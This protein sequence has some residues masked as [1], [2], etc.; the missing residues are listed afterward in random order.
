M[1]QDADWAHRLHF[2][3][4]GGEGAE[5]LLSRPPRLLRASLYL[6]CAL[7]AAALLW[8]WFSKVDIYI[9][10]RGAVRPA[11]D[12]A[13]IQAF[14]PGRITSVKVADGERVRAGEVLFILDQ[15]DSTTGLSQA[16]NELEGTRKRLAAL[17]RSA[18]AL[19][20]Q[21][22]AQAASAR[23]NTENAGI[24]VQRAREEENARTA[25]VEK[26]VELRAAA[27]L[28]LERKQRLF[29]ESIVSDLDVRSAETQL[30]VAESSQRAA[31]SNLQAARQGIAVAE[32]N[33]R[34]LEQQEK[35]AV[36]E[37][38]REA[39]AL[40][41]EILQLEEQERSLAL[42]A[43]T[44]TTVGAHSVGEVA[45]LGTVLATIA[46]TGAP[47]IVE[48]WVSNSDAG[49]LRE[50][51]GAR[52]K[53]KFDAFPFRDYGTLSGKLVEVSPDADFTSA[54]GN[55]YRVKITMDSLQLHRGGRRG[56]V[57]LGMAVTAEIV[58]EEERIFLLLF[59]EVRD[60]VAYE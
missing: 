12:L 8:S 46:P 39:E 17:R 43:G 49:P 26:A 18:T 7:L 24:G 44:V 37:R 48:S 10:S 19:E 5:L 47:W 59:R 53:L 40:S 2:L 60:R 32:K 3:E 15:R 1:E 21:H 14:V 27:R 13:K 56:K 52:V 4:P 45:Q 25:D 9:T 20:E 28:D 57:R 33:Y 31:E 16:V 41:S 22:R 42:V 23:I 34:L 51:I 38:T 55:A 30:H 29:K 58:K 36:Q 11:G 35:A 50:K 6:L 54:L